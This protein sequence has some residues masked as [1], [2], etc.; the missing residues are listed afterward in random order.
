MSWETIQ[1]SNTPIVEVSELE[2][3][4][5]YEA[6]NEKE[7][8]N[9]AQCLFAAERYIGNFMRSPVQETHLK[10]TLA[11]RHY[12][13]ENYTIPSRVTPHTNRAHMPFHPVTGVSGVR[14]CLNHKWEDL[15]MESVSIVREGKEFY[16]DLNNLPKFSP[17]VAPILEVIFQAGYT[18]KNLPSIIRS[19]IVQM[20]AA[21]FNGQPNE[22]KGLL[23]LLAEFRPLR[24]VV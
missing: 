15:P 18:H 7:K 20:A 24:K 5:R 10:W 17:T 4:L 13:H 8:K 1:E 16:L 2:T 19:T 21:M 14:V 23:T 3:Y 6:E 22:M 12:Q 11:M 9:M